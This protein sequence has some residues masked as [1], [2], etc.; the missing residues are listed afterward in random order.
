MAKSATQSKLRR[1]NEGLSVEQTS[2]LDNNPLPP[3]AEIERIQ[4]L[5]PNYLPWI[6]DMA[7][8]ELD[9]RRAATTERIRLTDKDMDMYQRRYTM[10]VAIMFVIFLILCACTMYCVI[11][12][13]DVA[14][15]IFGIADAGSLLAIIFKSINNRH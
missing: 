3:A 8:Q 4:N 10:S 5:D 12:G 14:G 7:R 13:Y 1:S 9:A 11:Q 6:M 2:V 15:T